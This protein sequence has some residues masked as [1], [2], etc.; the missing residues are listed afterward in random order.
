MNGPDIH[1]SSLLMAN[2]S[3]LFRQDSTQEE[4]DSCTRKWHLMATVSTSNTLV[5]MIWPQADYL[6]ASLFASLAN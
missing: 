1:M 3:V 2:R 5:L 6:A 4:L